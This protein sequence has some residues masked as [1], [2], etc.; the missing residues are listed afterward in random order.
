MGVEGDCEGTAAPKSGSE[1]SSVYTVK[2]AKWTLVSKQRQQMTKET[3][4]REL[5]SREETWSP[6]RS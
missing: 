2:E 5:E 4:L 1:A 6:G 3:E